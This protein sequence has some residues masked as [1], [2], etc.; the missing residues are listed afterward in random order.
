[1]SSGQTRTI[2]TSF[3]HGAVGIIP[4]SG[5]GQRVFCTVSI[6]GNSI[7]FTLSADTTYTG[8]WFNAVGY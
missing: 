1:M 7:T 2:Y 8:F 4:T 3:S 5:S 6:S